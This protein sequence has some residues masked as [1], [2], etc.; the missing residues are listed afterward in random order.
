MRG[1]VTVVL[2]WL[3]AALSS[4]V[5][6]A[7]GHPLV[8]T[9][10]PDVVPIVETLAGDSVECL[11][12]LPPGVDPHGFSVSADTVVGLRRARLMVYTNSAFLHFER[13]LRESLAGVPAVDWPDYQAHGARLLD[14]PGL[15]Q[16]FH[17]S[18]LDWTNARAIARALAD[19]L[20]GLGVDSALVQARLAQFEH[21]VSAL[22]A[23]SAALVEAAGLKG[24]AFV[25][26]DACLVYTVSNMGY[27]VGSVL[28]TEGAGALSGRQLAQ[29]VERLKSGE[30]AGVV[31]PDSMRD[32][33]LGEVSRQVAHDGHSR[34]I[35][36]RFLQP[37]AGASSYLSEAYYN[38]AALTAAAPEPARS[39]SAAVPPGCP[40]RLA[41]AVLA[42][43]LVAIGWLAA[44]LRS[45]RRGR[46]EVAGAG[47]FEGPRWDD[48]R[49]RR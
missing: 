11:S 47:I 38:V 20:P 6:A 18:W 1:G 28:M 42:A 19:A 22:E 33:K 7:G 30:L 21:E 24:A 31:C 44:R 46:A 25:V 17:G 5:A 13:H 2:A 8:V 39:A 27:R 16:T 32:S 48:W 35:Y 40:W 10:I 3:V 41:G 23:T 12:V 29:V 26:A 43:A 14:F 4:P 45:C 49:H 36:A 15:P 9:S 34:V 37:T